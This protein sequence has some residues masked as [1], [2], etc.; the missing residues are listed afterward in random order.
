[1]GQDVE[2]IWSVD[3]ER[4]LIYRIMMAI[5][6]Q[7][8]ARLLR[9]PDVN[10]RQFGLL[11]V[12]V[13]IL[14]MLTWVVLFATVIG[15][16]QVTFPPNNAAPGPLREPPTIVGL[17]FFLIFFPVGWS[18]MLIVIGVFHVVLGERFSRLNDW[19]N[20]QPVWLAI[21][22]FPVVLAIV[23]AP[24]VAL[25]GMAR[26]LIGIYRSLAG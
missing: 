8:H 10:L 24:I 5:L 2:S 12:V 13:G 17:L 4:P 11:Q 23:L 21:L 20:G 3:A 1:M 16:L 18:L 7:W 22:S 14:G 6:T 9:S 19:W 26:S 15:L 25:V